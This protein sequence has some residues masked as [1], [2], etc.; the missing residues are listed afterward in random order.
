MGTWRTVAPAMWKL[1]KRMMMG[2][3]AW[4][5]VLPEA[6]NRIP[7]ENINILS[8]QVTFLQD[9]CSGVS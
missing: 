8:A 2:N 7:K 4:A 1:V 9:F 3:E 5:A 6:V